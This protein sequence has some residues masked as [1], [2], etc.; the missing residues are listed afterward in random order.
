MSE[1][2]VLELRNVTKSYPGAAVVRVLEKASMVVRA[3][4][5]VAIVGPSGSGKTTLLNLLGGLDQPDEGEVLLEG[6]DLTRKSP[7]ELARLR[8][9][10]IGFIFQ[11]HH[12]L[13]QCTA[14]EN[15]L[16]PRLATSSRVDSSTLERAHR[17]LDRVG[18]GAR[19][20]HLPGRLSGGERQR[21]AVVRAL[22]HRPRLVLGD[23]PTGA[24]DRQ[25]ASDVSRLLVEL[26]REEGVTLVVVTH[27]M[28]LAELMA[29]R[30]EVRGGKLA[31]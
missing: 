13:P 11:N 26:N 21:C 31:G 14:L 29:R 27:S 17:M 6:E 9:E 18:L 28:E 4:E 30:V 1:G 12:L 20:D 15:V 2:S 24:L 19:K 23:E 10:K 3:R 25:S 8:N 16:V 5:T 7:G 22:I